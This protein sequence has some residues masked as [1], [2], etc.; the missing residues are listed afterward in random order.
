VTDGGR[1]CVLAIC[2]V[3]ESVQVVGF[4]DMPADHEPVVLVIPEWP[5]ECTCQNCGWPEEN[6]PDAGPLLPSL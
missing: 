5:D 1:A 2:P 3:C 6:Q 4:K